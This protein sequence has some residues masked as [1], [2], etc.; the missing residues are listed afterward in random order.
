M[1]GTHGK[2]EIADDQAPPFL[3]S[4]RNL[5]ALVLLTLALDISLLYAFTRHFE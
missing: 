3:N 5:Y 4:W 2:L 1:A